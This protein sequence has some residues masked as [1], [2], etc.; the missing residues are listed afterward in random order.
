MDESEVEVNVGEAERGLSVTLG[1]ALLAF[2]VSRR[3]RVSSLLLLGAGAWLAHRGVTGCCALYDQLDVGT[4]EDDEEQR[5]DAVSHREVVV[6]AGVQA[7]LLVV[8]HRADVELVVEHAAPG[9]PAVGQPRPRAQQEQGRDRRRRETA[10][11]R[12]AAPR[13]TDSPR[14]ASPTLTSTSLSS[15]KATPRLR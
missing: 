1:A 3:R 12:S 9:D 10:K 4:V 2:A 8:L 5:L 14:S 7:L 6:G 15:I 11:A 13:V